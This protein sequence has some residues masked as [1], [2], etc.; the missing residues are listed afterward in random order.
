MGMLTMS[1]DITFCVSEECEQSENCY[2]YLKNHDTKN[3]GTVNMTDFY[4][5]KE[6]GNC[7]YR[8]KKERTD[9]IWDMKF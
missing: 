9:K 4:T 6:H 3:I 8:Y 7:I 1:L 5:S 2:R